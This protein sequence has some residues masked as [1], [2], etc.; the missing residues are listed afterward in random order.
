[1]VGAIESIRDITERKRDEE[2]LRETQ[3]RMADIINFLPDV[4]FVIDL[5][6]K[7]IS[8]NKAAEEMTGIKAEDMVGK[9]DYEYAIP[10]YGRRQQIIIDLV[11]KKDEELEQNYPFIERVGN[12]LIG[13][14]HCPAVR[15][16]GAYLRATASPLYDSHGR[17]VGA[18][19]SI[20]DATES[21]KAEE[22]MKY[23]SLHD[24]PSPAFTTAPSLK[25]RCTSCSTAASMSCS[26][27]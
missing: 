26:A 16:T 23:I 9:G 17:I 5:E 6:G 25:N 8:W 4:T 22:Q 13:E 21:K 19:E 7:V 1:M 24:S 27:L 18:I 2:V 12:S 11:L 20:R 14:N 10:F 3:Q 15:G